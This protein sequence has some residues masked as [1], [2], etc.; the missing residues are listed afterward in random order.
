MLLHAPIGADDPLRVAAFLAETWKGPAYPFPAFPG[1][2]VA[3]AGDR[4]GTVLEIYPLDHLNGSLAAAMPAADAAGGSS[5]PDLAIGVLCR[6]TELHRCAAR[7]GWTSSAALG[8]ERFRVVELWVENK[9]LVE[10]SQARPDDLG[11]MLPGGWERLVGAARAPSD[12][13]AAL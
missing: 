3:L 10:S 1:S 6:E 11:G 9:L 5:E 8:I 4:P 7:Q 12:A 2:F 13:V